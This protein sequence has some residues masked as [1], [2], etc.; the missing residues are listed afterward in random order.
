MSDTWHRSLVRVDGGFLL[1]IGLSLFVAVLV[2][3]FTGRGPMGDYLHGMAYTIGFA[4]AFGLAI[5][6]AVVL[7]GMAKAGDLRPWMGLA[8]AVHALLGGANLLFWEIFDQTG[9]VAMG[10]IVTIIHGLFVIAHASALSL[11]ALTANAHLARKDL[12]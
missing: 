10:V 1:L 8:L 11:P 6:I 3:Y 12:P 7:L 5:M 2:G 9:M 4:E